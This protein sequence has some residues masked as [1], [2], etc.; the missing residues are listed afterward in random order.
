MMGLILDNIDGVVQNIT[1]EVH[2]ASLGAI[3]NKVVTIRSTHHPLIST[4]IRKIIRKRKRFF[5][6]YKRTRT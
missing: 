3:P 5:R 4:K 1:E 6:Q 2:V